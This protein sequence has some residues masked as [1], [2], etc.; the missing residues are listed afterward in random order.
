MRREDQLAVY[1]SPRWRA[2]RRTKLVSVDFTCERCGIVES[3]RG[4][5][6][7][8]DQPMTE[9]GEPYPDTSELTALCRSCHADVHRE[10]RAVKEPP[11]RTAWRKRLREVED[12]LRRGK[13]TKTGDAG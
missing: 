13:V 12:S 10:L 9:G 3:G 11:E 4:I 8:H 7:H 6:V 1:H 5:E 2:L